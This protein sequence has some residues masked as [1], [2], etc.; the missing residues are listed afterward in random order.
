[1]SHEE[2]FSVLRHVKGSAVAQSHKVHK[3]RHHKNTLGTTS[4][5]YYS[6][7][8]SAF[9][10]DDTG[11]VDLTCSFKHVFSEKLRQ[12]YEFFEVR[13]AASIIR[14]TNPHQFS[15]LV[16]TLE[17]FLLYTDDLI[18]PGGQESTIAAR[19]NASF[20]RQGWREAR[21]DTIVELALSLTPFGGEAPPEPV[22]SE[23]RNQGYMVDNFLG[24]IALDV[25]WNAKDGNLDR[26]LAA[27]RFLYDSAL[28][29]GAVIITRTQGKLRELG[30]KLGRE[31][32][33]T[34]KEAKRIL[35]TTT[36]NNTDKLVPR[37]TRG[38]AGGCPVLVVAICDRTW[39]G[40]GIPIPK[41]APL[42]S[43]SSDASELPT[44]AQSG[45]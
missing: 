18:L 43:T 7:L 38:D 31:S 40:R 20:R 23:V 17:R 27:Y 4:K 39:A 42:V 5:P 25:E 6:E 12:K 33:M 30:R 24:R 13:N 11:G 28:I 21:V 19:L 15:H 1:M 32:G 22:I 41:D 2:K 10:G 8:D 14:H 34:E 44:V 36:T 29:D 3:M 16:D 26:D 45:D 9:R 37:I 35:G